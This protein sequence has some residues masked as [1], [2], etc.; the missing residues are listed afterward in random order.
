[1]PIHIHTSPQNMTYLYWDSKRP[2]KKKMTGSCVSHYVAE[3]AL[4]FICV[5]QYKKGTFDR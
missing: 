4:E 1:M 3:S 5:T 2:Y